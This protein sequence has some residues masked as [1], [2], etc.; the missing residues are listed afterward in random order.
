[1]LSLSFSIAA[2][3]S[4]LATAPETSP[5]P[6]D[7][8]V[9]Q[10]VASH[11]SSGSQT[12]VT[13]SEPNPYNIDIDLEHLPEPELEQL[14]KK[15]LSF[16]PGLRYWVR[17]FGRQ[18][19]SFDASAPAHQYG[20]IHQA[21]LHARASYG[22]VSAF[23]QLQDARTWGFEQSTTSNDAN[24]DL[25]QGYFD[26][27]GATGKLSGSLR[28]GRQEIIIGSRRLFAERPWNPNGQSFDALRL[29]GSSTVVELDV[30]AAMLAPP[31]T[32]E[33][34]VDGEDVS[35]STRGGY[36]GGAYLTIHA[37]PA[38]AIDAA[39]FWDY[40]GPTAT[41]LNRDRRIISPGVRLHGQPVRGWNYELEGYY[42]AGA[43]FRLPHRAWA[44]AALTSYEF[45]VD[46]RPTPYLGYTLASGQSCPPSEDGTCALGERSTEFFDFYRRRHG[47]QGIADLALMRNIGDL[48]TGVGLKPHSKLGLNVDYHLFHLQQPD[49][50]WWRVPDNLV[51]AGFDPQNQARLLGQEFDFRLLARPF[52]AEWQGRKLDLLKIEVGYALFLPLAAAR[53]IAGGSDPRHFWYLWFTTEF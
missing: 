19:T 26:L 45:D 40:E 2:S 49:G 16:V 52:D 8:D 10:A 12:A 23:V 36:V 4:A 20:I 28:L 53:T 51:G 34:Q 27:A 32:I 30:F 41:D 7:R 5:R 35:I 6:L 50:R 44:L 31:R 3:L 24:T 33:A 39:M 9:P 17:G 11:T 29:R 18:V 22:P 25:H 43:Q 48:E 13:A 46:T 38:I 1:M 42:Q 21:R 37:H 15:Q 14:K 47:Y